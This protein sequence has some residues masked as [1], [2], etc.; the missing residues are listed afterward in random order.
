[1]TIPEAE[2]IAFDQIARAVM[3]AEAQAILAAANR[4][5]DEIGHAV[6]LIIGHR[7]KVIVTGIGKSG[8]VAHKIAATLCS[9]GTPAVFLHPAEATHGDLGVYTPG[10]PTILLSRSG[11][12]EELMRLVPVLREFNSP[13]IGILGNR[14]SWLARNVDVVLDAW[15]AREA[16]PL[17]LAPT[18]SAAVALVLGDALAVALMRARGFTHEDFARYH[19]GGQ[20]GRNLRLRVADVMHTGGDVPWIAIDTSLRE[21]VI[22]MTQRPLGAA[23]VV[24]EHY[25]LCG[26]ITDGDL[27]RA[28]LAN[29]DIRTLRASDVMTA[30][31]VKVSASASLKEALQLMED[32][33]RQ[34]SVLPVIGAGEACVGLLRIHDI[35]LSGAARINGSNG[36]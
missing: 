25:R 8:H 10:D 11:S 27:R 2:H 32:R 14:H 18:S 9:A 13:L 33:P 19:P 24:D 12:T 35:Y 20:L 28:L 4:L 7:G 5:G 30:H 3:E 36:L 6:R 31:P 26:L 21:V 17:N 1:M 23:P 22:R 16:D 29:D 15:V 34:I